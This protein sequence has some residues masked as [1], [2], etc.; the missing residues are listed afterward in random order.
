[1]CPVRGVYVRPEVATSA[2]RVVVGNAAYDMHGSHW[3]SASL[4]V[5]LPQHWS[6]H[7]HGVRLTAGK[8]TDCPLYLSPSSLLDLIT[9]RKL[10][11][12]ITEAG[13]RHQVPVE[14]ASRQLLQ[15]PHRASLLLRQPALRHGVAE[16][17]LEIQRPLAS[18]TPD[19]SETRPTPS[20]IHFILPR[21]QNRRRW[22]LTPQIT[23]KTSS[24]VNMYC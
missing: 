17:H 13:Y 5:T 2:Q 10:Y 8:Q 16:S 15:L 3:G 22:K 19:H 24:I 1:M 14:G 20:Q 4:V 6:L 9:N 7:S 11:D 21:V 12:V 18:I 23:T